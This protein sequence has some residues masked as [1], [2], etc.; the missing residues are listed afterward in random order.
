[1]EGRAEDVG[2][3]PWRGAA[4]AVVARSFAAPA[5]TAECAAPLLRAGGRLVVSEPPEADPERWPVAGLDLLHL[6]LGPRSPGSPYTQ[7]LYQR[8]TC[9]DRFPRRN[10]QPAAH[11]LF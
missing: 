5:A 1:V 3:G 2:R 9:P 4:D 6:E 7:T 10:G 8:A 11:P